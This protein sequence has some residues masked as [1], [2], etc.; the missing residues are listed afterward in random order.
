MS[1]LCFVCNSDQAGHYMP[2][3]HP[4]Q[5]SIKFCSQEC[6]EKLWNTLSTQRKESIIDDS[7]PDFH[8]M[9]TTES[10]LSIEIYTND[11]KMMRND[12]YHHRSFI[13]V[14]FDVVK[15]S[16][17]GSGRR[18]KGEDRNEL[19]TGEPKN[20]KLGTVIG[21]YDGHGGDRVVRFLTGENKKKLSMNRDL[22]NLIGDDITYLN[23]D[24][25]VKKF[26]VDWDKKMY[27]ELGENRDKSGG[28]TATIAM[29]N[30]ADVLNMAWVGDSEAIYY[31]VGDDKESLHTVPHKPNDKEETMRAEKKGLGVVGGRVAG[32]LAVSRAFGDFQFKHDFSLQKEGQKKYDPDGPISVIPSTLIGNQ[33]K[34]IPSDKESYLVMASDGM[35]DFVTKKDV[36]NTIKENTGNVK[37]I[38]DQLNIK[39]LRKSQQEKIDRDDTTII[40]L[41]FLPKK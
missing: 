21:V 10:G 37:K 32:V 2:G 14:E 3:L 17:K 22:K 35:W 5:K 41:R 26:F 18:A 12:P 16:D 30:R 36:I 25:Q 6:Q 7:N 1:S 31:I 34:K 33:G 20:T 8:G 23:N 24:K 9:H 29:I 28:S 19:N 27:Q 11:K 13:G 15:R 40:V 4:D 39:L 38:H